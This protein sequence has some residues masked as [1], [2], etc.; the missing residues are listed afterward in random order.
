MREDR[1]QLVSCARHKRGRSPARGPSVLQELKA[2]ARGRAPGQLEANAAY[3]AYRGAPVDEKM[4]VGLSSRPNPYMHQAVPTGTI[5]TT[6]HDSRIMQTT[7]GPAR[8]VTNA[9][10]TVERT[11]V[12]IAA[13]VTVDSPDF[14]QHEPMVDADSSGNWRRL[15]S[16]RTARAM[17]ADTGYW[18]KQQMESVVSRGMQVLI[19][20]TQGL[21][22]HPRPGWNKGFYALMWND[23]VDRARPSV[24]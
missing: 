20:P 22:T 17:V 19:R 9:Q 21:R 6:D 10:A 18:H 16:A 12:I 11:P 24:V 3:E 8:R 15:V 7:G 1:R 4:V 2:A 13:E 5:N 14:G 23:A